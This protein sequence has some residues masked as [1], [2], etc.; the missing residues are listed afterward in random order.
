MVL[1]CGS[2]CALRCLAWRSFWIVSCEIH[3]LRGA[4]CI[5]VKVTASACCVAAKTRAYFPSTGPSVVVGVLSVVISRSSIGGLWSYLP[6][7][8]SVVF[9]PCSA[10]LSATSLPR[11]PECPFT[12]SGCTLSHGS[13]PFTIVIN[14][15]VRVLVVWV[16]EKQ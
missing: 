9:V 14:G 16:E 13:R 11:C 4:C 2:S 3:G 12:H 10:S 7:N 1:Y 6:P 5:G 8:A 15:R